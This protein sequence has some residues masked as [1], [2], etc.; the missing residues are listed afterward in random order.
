MKM[1]LVL[2]LLIGLGNVTARAHA[3]SEGTI[4]RTSNGRPKALLGLA[5]LR[6][7]DSVLRPTA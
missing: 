7:S 2:G 3:L 1:L 5:V 4:F 6:L